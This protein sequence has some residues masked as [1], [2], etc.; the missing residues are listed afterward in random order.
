MNIELEIKGEKFHLV[1]DETY[2]NYTTKLEHSEKMRDYSAEYIQRLEEKL[3]RTLSRAIQAENKLLREKLN[4]DAMV[5]VLQE[6][7]FW[8]RSLVSVRCGRYSQY[9]ESNPADKFEQVFLAKADYLDDLLTKIK[10]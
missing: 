10:E 6:V 1:D 4:K 3:E 2:Q 7:T 8:L 9:I 5:K